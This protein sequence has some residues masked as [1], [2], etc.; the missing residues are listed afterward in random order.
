[1]VLTILTILTKIVDSFSAKSVKV[2]PEIILKEGGLMAKLK[3]IVFDLYLFILNTRV[4]LVYIPNSWVPWLLES[5]LPSFTKDLSEDLWL[6]VSP[7][8]LSSS[9]LNV[10]GV[11]W[12]GSQ[13][14]LA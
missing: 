4:S 10:A 9:L 12:S 5:L 2:K 3:Q 1:M 7:G 14:E 6:P 13:F 11:V 8:W